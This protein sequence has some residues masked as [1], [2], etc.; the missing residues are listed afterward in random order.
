[1]MDILVGVA[2]FLA[3]LLLLGVGGYVSYLYLDDKIKK[4]KTARNTRIAC[5]KVK[6]QIALRN[7]IDYFWKDT[8]TITRIALSLIVLILLGLATDTVLGILSSIVFTLIAG[9]FAFFA[10]KSFFEFEAKTKERLD[11]F[12]NTIRQAVEKEAG[13]IEAATAGMTDAHGQPVLKPEVF[14]FN[15]SVKKIPFPPLE[16]DSK[17][18]KII[19][20][21]RLEFLILGVNYFSVCKSATLYNLL[22]PAQEDTDKL[23]AEK[24]GALGECSE[25]YYSQVQRIEYDTAKECVRIIFNFDHEDIEFPCKKTA[26]CRKA[27]TGAFRE[28]LRITER[29]R[30]RKRKREN[31]EY[32]PLDDQAP[33]EPEADGSLSPIR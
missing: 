12:E 3:S 26:A 24:K 1:M 9:L 7:W 25:F 19:R 28:R 8:K 4:K 29:Q 5:R 23:C 11:Q 20:T 21:R 16:K 17:K 6:R 27:A 18:Q 13:M 10:Y 14:E 32:V 31:G 30:L 22:Q 15:A 33:E 2:L